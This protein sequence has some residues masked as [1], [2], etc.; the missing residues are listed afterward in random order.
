MRTLTKR[1]IGRQDFVDNQIYETLQKLIP[2][3]KMIDWDIEIIGTIREAV[4]EQIVDERRIMN[5]I[6]FYPYLKL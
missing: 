2:P 3:S 6:K 5:E 1:Q 4:R